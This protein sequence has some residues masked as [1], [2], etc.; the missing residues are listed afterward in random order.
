MWSC[1]VWLRVAIFD[2]NVYPK[3]IPS[4]RVLIVIGISDVDMADGIPCWI[5]SV[6]VDVTEASQFIV[7]IRMT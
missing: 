5:L 7:P 3:N 1:I 2:M 6:E 4:L